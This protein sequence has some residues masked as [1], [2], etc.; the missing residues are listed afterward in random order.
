[1]NRFVSN[2]VSDLKFSGIRKFFDVAATMEDVVSLGVGEP[3]FLTPWAIREEAIYSLEKRR[4]NYSSNAGLLELRREI[5]K[6]A[7]ETIGVTYNPDNEICVTVGASEGIDITLRTIL[8]PGEEVLV[9]EPCYVSY[10]PCIVLAGG[11]PVSVKTSAENGFKVTKEDIESKITSKTKAILI[12]YPNNP[13]GATATKKDLEDIAEVIIKHDL[14]V[15][16][17]EIYSELTYD[18]MEHVSIAKLPGMFERTVV[19]NGFSKSFS[20]TGWRLGYALAPKEIM[21]HM[22]KVHQYVIMCAPTIS[23]Y[24]GIEALKHCREDV[25]KMRYEYSKRRM[26]LVDGMKK[27]GLDVNTPGGA[28]YVFPSIEK[29]NLTSEEFC[30]KLLYQERLAVVPGNAFGDCGEGFVRCSYAYKQESLAKA[31]E[32]MDK[33]LYTLK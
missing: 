11:V 25:E 27:L 10:T 2:R 26:F 9:V 4:T 19:L 16:S 12:S 13:T 33:F 28:F 17:D 32:R 14:F 21:T 20:M 22:V 29:T 5:S 3:D 7:E 1:M 24:A 8:N 18:D 30:E 23:Q 6:Y 15:I 31:L